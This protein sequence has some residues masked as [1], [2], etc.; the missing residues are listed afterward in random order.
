VLLQSHGVHWW[1]HA[2]HHRSTPEVDANCFDSNDDSSRVCVV[3]AHSLGKQVAKGALQA[4]QGAGK[5]NLM[6]AV[7]H[8]AASAASS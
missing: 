5:A 3:N 8:A 2:G 4:W 6:L 1:H 7:A